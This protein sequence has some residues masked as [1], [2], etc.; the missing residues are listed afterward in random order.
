M[1]IVIGF[2]C[3]AALY[4]AARVVF[5]CLYTVRPDQRAV[6]TSFGA[7]QKLADKAPPPPLTGEERERYEYPQVRVIGPGGPYFKLPWQ[8]VHKVSVATQAV[9]LSWDPT[10]RQDTIEAVTKDNLTTG[11]NGQIRY[12]IS[13]NNLYAYLFGVA[14]PLE[15]V[16]GYFVSVLR[17]RIAN[18]E[19]P[20]GQSLLAE[21][22]IGES[23]LGG[24]PSKAAELSEGVSINDLR[25]NLPLL[26]QYMEEQCRSTT[27]RYGIEL[28]AALITEIDPPPEVD[29]ALSAINST[30]NQVAADISTAR[31]DAE[32]QITMSARAVEIAT[33]NAQAE[34]APLR[35]LA[36]TL[37]AIKQQGGS[38][39]LR[40]YLRNLRVPLYKRADRIV[41]S[42]AHNGHNGGTV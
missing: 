5:G 37:S 38:D 3:G 16:M 40:A 22:E 30:R 12:R 2:M 6:V 10:K 28:D 19:D 23:E 39:C 4:V 29:R 8:Q 20:K 31:A 13:E 21:S 17:E 42:E 33:N 18:F 32:Q 24:E 9:D 14:S 26:N 1:F 34:V 15:H 25:K 11:V 41:Q 7:V 27:G 36:G 35:E